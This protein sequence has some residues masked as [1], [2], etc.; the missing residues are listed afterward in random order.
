MEGGGGEGERLV[1]GQSIQ[2]E[3]SEFEHA[4]HHIR[5]KVDDHDMPIVLVD[6]IAVLQS[7]ST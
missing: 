5:G 2:S 7:R 6:I 1:S 4:N 3:S